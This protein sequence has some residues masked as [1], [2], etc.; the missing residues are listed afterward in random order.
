MLYSHVKCLERFNVS[1]LKLGASDFWNMPDDSSTASV[2]GY[3]HCLLTGLGYFDDNTGYNIDRIMHQVKELPHLKNTAFQ[4]S[5][6]EKCCGR[7][8]NNDPADVWAFRGFRCLMD[9]IKKEQ[10]GGYEKIVLL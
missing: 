6:F 7:N 1:T 10:M 8:E 3:V 9:E 5:V 4:R 2:R